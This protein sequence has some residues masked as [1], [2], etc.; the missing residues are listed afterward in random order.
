M[1]IL[2]GIT[3]SVAALLT[4]ELY[5]ALSKLGDTKVVPTEKARHFVPR[6]D[7]ARLPLVC[8][9]HQWRWQK[10]GDPVLHLDLREWADILVLAPAS[11]HTIA[12]VAHGLADNLLG[13]IALAWDWRKPFLVAPAMNTAMWQAQPTQDNLRKIARYGCQVIDPI[14]KA[15]A[16]GDEGRGALADIRSIVAAIQEEMR[17]QFPLDGKELCQGIPVGNHP[18]AFGYRRRHDVHTGVDLYVAPGLAALAHV[19]AVEPGTIRAISPFTG[20]SAGFAWW[21]DTRA[22]LVEG[23][24]GCVGY[25]EMEPLPGLVVG[26][27]VKKGERLGQVVPVL[28]PGKERPDIPGHSRWMLHVELYERDL[29]NVQW[30][31]WE[32]PLTKP[33]QLLDPTPFLLNAKDGCDR[34]LTLGEAT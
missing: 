29:E 12:K 34:T 14:T 28:R 26:Q 20:P 16:C 25:C 18:G 9:E 22:V 2:L 6:D 10:P 21:L 19:R 24:S 32:T 23:P 5:D 4:G 17:W 33:A 1:R 15:L 11:A 7:L 8:D 27:K 30:V 13:N 3:G 31:A